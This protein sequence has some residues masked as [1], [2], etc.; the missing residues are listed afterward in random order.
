MNR[1]TSITLTAILVVATVAVPLAA[2]SA[3]PSSSVQSESGAGN[4]SIAP[5]ERF[6][7]AVGVQNAEINGDVS[8]RTF[9]V[10]IANAASDEAKAA[11]VADQFDA[12]EARQTALE[13]RLAGLNESRNTGELGEG[14]YQAEVAPIVAEMRTVERQAAAAE[15]VAME[16]PEDA[17]DDQDVDVEAIRALRDRAGERGG[18]E[19]AAIARSI[20]GDDIDR[21]TTDD[22]TPADSTARPGEGQA[23][24][25]DDNSERDTVAT[26]TEN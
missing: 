16:L 18:P 12:S 5:G 22:R 6:A 17:L 1:T 10:R 21:S 23:D 7:A 14:R 9:E 8:E 15:T 25:R 24:D 13:D 4:E 20:T 19:T 2:A 11:V 3:V 26:A